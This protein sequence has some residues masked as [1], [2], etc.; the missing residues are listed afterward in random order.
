MDQSR[1][2]SSESIAKSRG[3]GAVR[4]A[5]YLPDTPSLRADEPLLSLAPED[6]CAARCG[7]TPPRPLLNFTAGPEAPAHPQHHVHHVR[8]KMTLTCTITTSPYSH[9]IPV[10]MTRR[11]SSCKNRMRRAASDSILPTSPRH[12]GSA[13]SRACARAA[14]VRSSAGTRLA[15]TSRHVRV[16]FCSERMRA[17]AS[18]CASR[19]PGYELRRHHWT[20]GRSEDCLGTQMIRCCKSTTRVMGRGHFGCRRLQQ[21]PRGR[22]RS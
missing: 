5:P 18:S 4:P 1:A 13:T 9:A 8:Y 14:S 3:Y 19:T 12:G 21:R 11:Q 7:H 16:G 20:L 10:R 22:R 17:T 6:A 15:A 2:G